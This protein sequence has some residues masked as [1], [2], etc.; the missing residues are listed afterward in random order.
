MSLIA[1]GQPTGI[2]IVDQALAEVI[3]RM[4]HSL[5]GQ[6]RGYYL[7]GSY[8]VGEAL[9]A[10]DIDL[11]AVLAGEPSGE[12]RA[13]FAEARE[14]CKAACPLALDLTTQGE[15]A[16]LHTGGVWFQSAS[17][18]L[19][20]VDIR[21]LVPRKPV[22]SHL[23]DTM[24]SAAGLIARVRGSP[25]TLHAPLGYP[26]RHAPACGYA[27]RQVAGQA[28][29]VG[30][31]DLLNITLAIA[32]ALTLRAAGEY[33]GTGK[34]ADIHAQYARWVGGPWAQ[35]VADIF[36]IC[37]GRWG[38]EIPAGAADLARLRRMC[39]GAL[40]LENHF[41]VV[42]RSFLLSELAQ[43]DQAAARLAAGA[44]ARIIYPGAQVRAALR[45]ARALDAAF[46]AHELS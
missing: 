32:S 39:Q 40:A 17:R 33:V 26:D 5:P 42:Y 8:A 30:T 25:P 9:P 20:G 41:L 1:L 6:V 44:L 27:A 38:Y 12:L 35:L 31:K 37:R 2:A 34:K 22:A 43:P 14:Q 45:Q 36:Q 18:W 29:G 23:R 10:S 24:H 21:P 4:E 19:Y 7:V 46:A 16:L 3:A 11:L 13:H 28:R 15:L